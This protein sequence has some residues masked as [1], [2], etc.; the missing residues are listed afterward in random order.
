MDAE[1]GKDAVY[2]N[3]GHAD[4]GDPEAAIEVRAT[5]Q[6]AAAQLDEGDCDSNESK[7]E[8]DGFYGTRRESAAEGGGDDDAEGAGERDGPEHF[9]REGACVETKYVCCGGDEIAGREEVECE[10]G[11]AGD[12]LQQ[13]GKSMVQHRGQ[14]RSKSARVC[15]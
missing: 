8:E 5:Q 3:S 1:R 9:F 12:R 6:R 11:D 10:G 7:C 14:H 15:V 13:I 2:R 4:S